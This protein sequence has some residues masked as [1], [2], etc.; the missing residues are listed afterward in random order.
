MSSMCY[1]QCISKMCISRNDFWLSTITMQSVGKYEVYL[2][3][4]QGQMVN[5]HIIE[6]ANCAG[7]TQGVECDYVN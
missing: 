5:K 2:D 4:N 6:S 1:R 7:N 3:Q